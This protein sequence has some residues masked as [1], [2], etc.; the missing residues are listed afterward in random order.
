[1]VLDLWVIF[2]WLSDLFEYL[3]TM[4]VLALKLEKN[5]HDK[6]L[7]IEIEKKS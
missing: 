6:F 3:Y 1:M 7:Q 4:H 2:K 5:E